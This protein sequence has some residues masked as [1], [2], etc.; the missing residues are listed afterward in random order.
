MLP[1]GPILKTQRHAAAIPS[2]TNIV[3]STMIQP[4]QNARFCFFRC[5]SS[6]ESLQGCQSALCALS[7]VVF[8]P[9]AGSAYVCFIG[10]LSLVFGAS[11][12]SVLLL[13]TPVSSSMWMAIEN[14]LQNAGSRTPAIV[15]WVLWECLE[16]DSWVLF[17][18][19]FLSPMSTCTVDRG[20]S[21]STNQIMLLARS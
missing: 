9:V 20:T 10:G 17:T 15:L 11:L 12:L 14:L 13:L 19:V 2:S 7:V 1:N 6:H 16:V 8:A 21:R 5:L 18:S 4:Q 3:T